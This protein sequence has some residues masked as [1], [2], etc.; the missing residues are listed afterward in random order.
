MRFASAAMI[1]SA[2]AVAIAACGDAGSASG[3]DASRG[4]VTTLGWE[5][6]DLSRGAKQIEIRFEATEHMSDVV[7][8]LHEDDDSVEIRVRAHWSPPAGGWTAYTQTERRIVQLKAPL[9]NR[10]LTGQ[11]GDW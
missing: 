2:I 7:V 9:G 1:G 4:E 5:P 10:V 8:A 3:R 6:V 11:Q